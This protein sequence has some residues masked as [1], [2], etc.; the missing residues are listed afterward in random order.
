LKL[1]EE[2]G[3][4]AFPEKERF[5]PDQLLG[6]GLAIGGRFEWIENVDAGAFAQA[7]RLWRA[8]LPL[9]GVA[10]GGRFGSTEEMGLALLAQKERRSC[11]SQFLEGDLALVGRL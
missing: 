6:A 11:W 2:A 1:K 7:E 10:V 4:D 9:G 5:G 3:L 8:Q